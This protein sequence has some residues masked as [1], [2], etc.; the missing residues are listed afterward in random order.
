MNRY[1]ALFLA[2]LPPLPR[3]IFLLRVPNQ[4]INPFNA[5]ATLGPVHNLLGLPPR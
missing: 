2:L 4:G 5:R 1:L 3:G